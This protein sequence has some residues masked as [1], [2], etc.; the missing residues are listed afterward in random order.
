[1]IRLLVALLLAIPPLQGDALERTEMNTYLQGVTLNSEEQVKKRVNLITINQNLKGVLYALSGLSLMFIGFGLY[2]RRK[3]LQFKKQQSREG[4]DNGP[5][6]GLE[7]VLDELKNLN[8]TLKNERGKVVKY[9][10]QK[11]E[12]LAYV[13]ELKSMQA[14]SEVRHKT[15]ELQQKFSDQK[16]EDI[17]IKLE[18]TA[19]S[20]YPELI[21]EMQKCYPDLNTLE[22]QYCMMLLLGYTIDDVM[23]ILNRS[24]KA[25]KSLRYRIRKKMALEEKQDL[26][27]FI[28]KLNSSQAPNADSIGQKINALSSY[29]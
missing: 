25:I 6:D 16:T 7:K 22:I 14:T 11:K 28:L 13:E 19:R 4:I 23:S 24:E 2:W 1:M 20:L 12:L 17:V 8:D 29:T 26:K 27:Q 10:V 9:E 5:S 21:D 15:I 18:N 3:A